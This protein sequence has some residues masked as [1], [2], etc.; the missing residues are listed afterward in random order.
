MVPMTD[1]LVFLWIMLSMILFV[2]VAVFAW[3]AVGVAKAFD[4]RQPQHA[5]K[6]RK[7]RKPI[8]TGRRDDEAP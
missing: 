1:T 8:D 7:P 4:S 6:V 3:A 5:P 2:F